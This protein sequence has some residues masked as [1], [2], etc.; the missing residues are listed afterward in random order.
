MKIALIG[1][2]NCGKTTL[3]NLLT[4]SKSKTANFPGV[5]V[6][7]KE[8]V[9]NGDKNTVIVD[10]PGIYSMTPYSP[11]ERVTSDF[12]KNEKIDLIINIV[13]VTNLGRNLYL[14]LQL[15]EYNIPMIIALNFCDELEKK[16]ITVDFLKLE[17]IL[18][19]KC[20]KISA[21]K[22]TGTENLLYFINN[23]KNLKAVKNLF[24]KKQTYEE[25]VNEKYGY[26]E[27]ILRLC[28]KKKKVKTF[29]A[30][31]ILTHPLF[32]YCAFFLFVAMMFFCAFGSFGNFLQEKTESFLLFLS[33][34]VGLILKNTG[35][36]ADVAE[37]ITEGFL[38]GI[39]EVMKFVPVFIILFFFLTLLEDSG[40]M[41]RIA[42]I[43]DGFLSKI[44]LSGKSIVPILLGYGCNVPAV[45]SLKTVRNEKERKMTAF[46][47]PFVPCGGKTPVLLL[48]S[49]FFGEKSFLFLM[50]AY[51]ISL[52]F[53]LLWGLVFSLSKNEKNKS[54]IMELPPYRLP[55]MK[56]IYFNIKE[57]TVELV[58]KIFT[59]IF[60]F[61]VITYLL[62]TFTPQFSFTN[63]PE[64]SILF[65]VSKKLVFLFE[66]LGLGNW[67]IIA[68]FLCGISAKEAV[69]STMELLC[70]NGNAFLL[71][72]FP[73]KISFL[74][75]F[76]FYT[77]CIGTIS[78]IKKEFGLSFT[79]K[80]I[81][82]HTVFAWCV[83]FV[84]YNF[85]CLFT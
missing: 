51:L 14:T 78:A 3:F 60:L 32:S 7:K 39:F 68:S 26:I 71:F 82:F 76:M 18:G 44:G 53:V 31:V 12:L 20:V 34:S 22:K 42:F 21:S 4:N 43:S 37:F 64:E 35:V 13:D 29:D 6:G 48:I 17:K 30:D 8:G 77:P 49:S 25:S 81:A 40:Y 33:K 54:F 74:M 11:E 5:T 75:F 10:L 47:L 38:K 61:S 24:S 84:F 70:E 67:E 16:G 41:A 65:F 36:N 57:K 55:T 1:N 2:P 69:L 83:T 72:S 56:N 9:M 59:V 19:V 66:P 28:V 27:E 58:K 63:N 46:L 73:Q 79:I 52:F 45:S 85:I 23:Y 62:K 50:F 15:F 80:T